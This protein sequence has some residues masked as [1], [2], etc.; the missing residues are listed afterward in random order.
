MEKNPGLPKIRINNDFLAVFH[1]HIDF[2][3]KS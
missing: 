2:L 1:C 3:S